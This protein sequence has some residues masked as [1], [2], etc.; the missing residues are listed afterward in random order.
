MGIIDGGVA[1]GYLHDA[2]AFVFVIVTR[3]ASRLRS[4]RRARLDDQPLRGFVEAG[5]PAGPARRSD[6]G[7]SPHHSFQG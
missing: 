3:L 6:E 5:S 2:I 1:V 4:D 7:P